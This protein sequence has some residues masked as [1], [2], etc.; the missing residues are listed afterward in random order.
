MFPDASVGSMDAGAVDASRPDAAPARDA[1]VVDAGVPGDA[2]VMDAGVADAA[3]APGIWHPAPR[4]RW[5][6][7][8]S[9]ALD[10]SINV[11]MYDV[12]LFD[13]P[14]AVVTTLHGQGRVVI[15]Y[16][17]T[18]Y[19]NWRP[20]VDVLPANVLGSALDGWPGERW[21]DIRHAA[22]RAWIQGRLDLAVMRGCDGVE[23]DNVD[24]Y[25]NTNGLGLTANDQL[26]FN[27][28][29][30]AQ[31]RARGLSV[32]LKNDLDQV[33]Q[34][35]VDFD[36]ALNEE[37]FQYDECDALTP[38]I[39]AGKAVFQVEYGNAATAAAVCPS[40]NTRG[41]STLIKN[42]DLDAWRLD[43]QDQ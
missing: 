6:W 16:F 19:E 11:A 30:A 37:C 28:F 10:T 41:F 3:A 29:V 22:V 39:T 23:P 43:C 35:V 2:S 38:F 5:Q 25:A 32:G 14:D 17:S 40:A 1:A 31:A 13:V 27:R 26:D 9:G 33:P 7:Q 42:L 36:W 21:V 24:G 34:L 18:Q 4:T 20:D 15:C 12:D 8:I